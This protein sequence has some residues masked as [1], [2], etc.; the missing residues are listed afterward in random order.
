MN[1]NRNINSQL[2]QWAEHFISRMRQVHS[3]HGQ[4]QDLRAAWVGGRSTRIS[5]GAVNRVIHQPTK[6]CDRSSLHPHQREL[7]LEPTK[8]RR[9]IG[10]KR[11]R[12][13]GGV[14]G[15]DGVGGA[16]G[17]SGEHDGVRDALVEVAEDLHE[18][19]G[20]PRRRRVQ[21]H[22]VVA[23]WRGAHRQR[24][25]RPPLLRR[26]RR[27]EHPHA[28]VAG[29]GQRRGEEGRG[30]GCGFHCSEGKVGEVRPRQFGREKEEWLKRG[31]FIEQQRRKPNL[32]KWSYVIKE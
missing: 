4:W 26:R 2:E 11:G 3:G 9:A 1:R 12:W 28:A 15:D 29:A 16:A 13:R 30:G 20:D 22:H 31:L 10:A 23:G 21:R 7:D 27:D 6:I 18:R 32:L 25:P 17:G 8:T 19:A 5:W 14:P 24:P